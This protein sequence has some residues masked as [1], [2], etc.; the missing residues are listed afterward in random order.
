[1]MS[2]EFRSKGILRQ[3][4][5]ALKTSFSEMAVSLLAAMTLLASSG[6][7]NRH[8]PETKGGTSDAAVV[9]VKL[10]PFNARCDGVTDDTLAIA[11]AVA[12]LRSGQTLLIPDRALV[13]TS[14]ARE[15]A[16]QITGLTNVTVIGSI[17]NDQ[18]GF[19]DTNW[20]SIDSLA[21]T[22]ALVFATTSVPHGLIVSNVIGVYC[23][24]VRDYSGA[25]VVVAATPTP[26]SFTYVPLARGTNAVTNISKGLIKWS[27]LDFERS[28]FEF[29]RC[30]WGDLRLD[31][32]APYVPQALRH[33]LGYKVVRF[34]AQNGNDNEN[35]RVALTASGAAYGVESGAFRDAHL[36]HLV[37]SRITFSG[38]DCGYPVALYG[39]KEI[40]LDV[41]ATNV[42]RCVYLDGPD[43]V[44]GRVIGKNYDNSGILITSHY[45]GSSNFGAR[46]FDL[47]MIDSGTDAK[48]SY[49]TLSRNGRFAIGISNYTDPG[50]PVFENGALRVQLK[51]NNVVGRNIIA[52]LIQ[53]SF[54][55]CIFRNLKI[56]G[57]IDRSGV[58]TLKNLRS[59]EEIFISASV[60]IMDGFQLQNF[61][62]LNSAATR[63][64]PQF[65]RTITIGHAA[66]D[67]VIDETHSDSTSSVS[68]TPANRLKQ[69]FTSD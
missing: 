51:Q 34:A 29:R 1:M 45:T 53:D 64:S 46:D 47:E 57:N 35:F 68:V 65:K 60:G 27:R 67:I 63:A 10:P 42:H 44:R 26:T 59:N 16:F 6:A 55:N 17:T 38:A 5:P 21:A 39:P 15:A 56:S 7:E 20:H 8:E 24:K 49:S 9:N 14:S 62:V 18:F 40:T 3:S 2:T 28:I 50:T 54:T 48:T 69:A 52:V 12:N 66:R 19:K 58:T 33:R 22:G 36:G 13:R 37:N 61:H 25:P 30:K 43:G 11:R 41:Q 23:E 32:S 31:Y 4:L